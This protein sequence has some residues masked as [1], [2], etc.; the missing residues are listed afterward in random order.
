M[1]MSRDSILSASINVYYLRL[2][3]HAVFIMTSNPDTDSVDTYCFDK[4]LPKK[5]LSNITV[6]KIFY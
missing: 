6:E 2:E 5:D 1:T 3:N 4:Q